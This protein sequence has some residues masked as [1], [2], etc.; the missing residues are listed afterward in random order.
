MSLHPS[1]RLRAFPNKASLRIG[2]RLVGAIVAMVL[3]W[4]D[5]ALAA[6]PH[7]ILLRGPHRS[8]NPIGS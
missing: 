7:V 8:P 5:G 2:S 1:L 4:C 3:L 6:G